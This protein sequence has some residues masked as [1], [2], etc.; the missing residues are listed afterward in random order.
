MTFVEEFTDDT[1]LKALA[2]TELKTTKEVS[3]I[4]GCSKRL[5]EY[6]LDKLVEEGKVT[7]EQ[8][9]ASGRFSFKYM[10]KLADVK[11]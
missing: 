9:K 6:R 2:L 4:I 8:V 3:T 11:D 10:W 1:F 5:V 7:K